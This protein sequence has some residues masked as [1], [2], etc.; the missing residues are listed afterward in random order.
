MSRKVRIFL[1]ML[2]MLYHLAPTK[3]FSDTYKWTDADGNLHFSDN[4]T[5]A[6]GVSGMA[7]TKEEKRSPPPGNA[8]HID[9]EKSSRNADESKCLSTFYSMV[10]TEFNKAY[11]ELG[12]PKVDFDSLAKVKNLGLSRLEANVSQWPKRAT[13]SISVLNNY[14]SVYV[15]CGSE[16]NYGG[17][18]R[19]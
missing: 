17:K 11:N 5:N 2:M 6:Q 18:W 10:T 16:Q 7:I 1:L 12:R 8:Q 14:I 4:P 19:P 15:Y 3:G 9:S 13:F